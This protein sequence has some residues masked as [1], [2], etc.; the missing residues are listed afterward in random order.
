MKTFDEF[1]NEQGPYHVYHK[2]KGDRAG[3]A[4][5]SHVKEHATEDEAKKHALKLDHGYKRPQ[6]F[7]SHVVKPH[8]FFKK[9]GK[10]KAGD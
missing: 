4:D 3:G 8:S 6:G 2:V 10:E 5:Y 1:L 7:H 9:H